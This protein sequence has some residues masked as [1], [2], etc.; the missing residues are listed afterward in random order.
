MKTVEISAS[1]AELID[2]LI[3]SGTCEDASQAVEIS[4]RL[5]D[6]KLQRLR[7]DV[8]LGMKDVREGRVAPLDMEAIIRKAKMAHIR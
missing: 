7:E 1:G 3:A 2:R 4:L 8:A 6:D 5:L